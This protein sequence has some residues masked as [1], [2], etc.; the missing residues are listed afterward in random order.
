M[1]RDRQEQFSQEWDGWLHAL[2]AA[3]EAV[4]HDGELQSGASAAGHCAPIGCPALRH[5]VLAHLSRPVG[6]GRVVLL[7]FPDR[8]NPAED[9]SSVPPAYSPAICSRGRLPR[10]MPRS[11]ASSRAM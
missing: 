10:S 9:I 11:L 3:M 4:S 2:V 7:G 5:A 1:V 6:A 8:I